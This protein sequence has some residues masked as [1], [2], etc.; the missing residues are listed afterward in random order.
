MR[1]RLLLFKDKGR[2]SMSTLNVNIYETAEAVV[3]RLEGEAG[4][5]GCGRAPQVPFQRITGS[6]AGIGDFS[7]CRNCKS[8]PA[9]FLGLLVNFRRSL[10]AQEPRIQMAGVPSRTFVNCFK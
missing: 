8:S 6:S 5:R 4:I 10:A 1:Q 3:I 9:L 7:I 2:F